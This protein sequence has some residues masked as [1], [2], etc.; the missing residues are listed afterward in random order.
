MN[1]IIIT[2]ILSSIRRSMLL[3]PLVVASLFLFAITVVTATTTEDLMRKFDWDLYKDCSAIDYVT[4][5]TNFYKCG[6]LEYCKVDLRKLGYRQAGVQG[7]P[8]L[9]PG[10]LIRV[11]PGKRYLLVL[12]NTMAETE[13]SSN[14]ET[15]IHTHGLHVSG[16]GNGDRITRKAGPGECIPYVWDI[17]SNHMGGTHWYHSHIDGISS[18]QVSLGAVGM[19][20][21]EDSYSKLIPKSLGTQVDSIQTFLRNEKSIMAVNLETSAWYSNGKKE[22]AFIT[23]IQ[24]EW[25]RI[26]IGIANPLQGD[27]SSNVLPVTMDCPESY[28]IAYDGVYLTSMP[29]G[30]LPRSITGS[31]RMDIAVRCTTIGMQSLKYG[32]AVIGRIKV[33]A[34]T[35]NSGSPYSDPAGSIPWASI[36]PPYLRDLRTA[37]ITNRLAIQLSTE[38]KSINNKQ[39]N[40]TQAMAQHRYGEINEWTVTGSFQHPLHIHIHHFQIIGPCGKHEI[41]QFYD[42]IAGVENCLV[43]FAYD[44]YAGMTVLHCH[45]LLHQDRT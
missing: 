35:P 43:R 13:E 12:K 8:C 29:G 38:T 10:P 9:S 33:V 4:P 34:G 5:E 2:M 39:W 7:S 25:T 1:N 18:G 11:I 36:R 24:N 44:D 32:D 6:V 30:T 16:D 17:P 40:A 20:I 22:G 28:V 23:I 45:D 15:N 26:R 3:L 42:T 41:G 31:S 19:I 27:I 14:L 21:V 37:N